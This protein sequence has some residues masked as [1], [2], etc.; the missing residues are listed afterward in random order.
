MPDWIFDIRDADQEIIDDLVAQLAAWHHLFPMIGA[1]ALQQLE[2]AGLKPL[3]AELANY[4]DTLNAFSAGDLLEKHRA[5]GY[6]VPG[7]DAAVTG[8]F[9]S[10]SDETEGTS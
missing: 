1:A 4:R 5:A 2:A 8:M 3:A 7:G 10:G 6:D 9:G